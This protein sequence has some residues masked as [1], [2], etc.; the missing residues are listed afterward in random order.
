MGSRDR[1]CRCAG[2]RQPAQEALRALLTGAKT[3]SLIKKRAEPSVEAALMQVLGTLFCR[4]KGGE[5]F[6][7]YGFRP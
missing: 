2:E 5:E 7:G 4:P 6:G 3:N 1:G